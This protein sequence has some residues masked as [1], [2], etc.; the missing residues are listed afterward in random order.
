MTDPICPIPPDAMVGDIIV[1]RYG[2]SAEIRCITEDTV[3]SVIYCYRWDGS[4]PGIKNYCVGFIYADGRKPNLS[5]TGKPKR[6][7]AQRD[8]AWL[9]KFI[10]GSSMSK[11]DSDRIFQIADRMEGKT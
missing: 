7:Q 9:R 3:Y 10:A 11:N 2:P 6:T 1:A 8:A 5:H 4:C